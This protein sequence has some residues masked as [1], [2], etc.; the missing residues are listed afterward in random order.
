M[1]AGPTQGPVPLGRVLLAALTAALLASVSHSLDH[2][3]IAVPPSARGSPLSADVLSRSGSLSDLSF[4]IRTSAEDFLQ[5]RRTFPANR[6][7]V[8]ICPEWTTP[9]TARIAMAKRPKRPSSTPKKPPLPPQTPAPKPTSRSGGKQPPAPPSQP[10]FITIADAAVRLGVSIKTIH[11]WIQAGKLAAVR[12]GR[13]IRIP[14]GAFVHFLGT[15][16]P[17]RP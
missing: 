16:P 13:Q 10:Q 6:P 5:D 8:S 17:A 2:L 3:S 11:R 4:R 9:E 14:L 12:V 1:G 15:L 7:N